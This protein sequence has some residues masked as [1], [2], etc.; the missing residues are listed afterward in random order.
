M[1][2][3]IVCGVAAILLVVTMAVIYLKNRKIRYNAL[4]Y[5]SLSSIYK[6]TNNSHYEESLIESSLM[7][8]PKKFKSPKNPNTPR[9]PSTLFTY[10]TFH[11]FGKS[12]LK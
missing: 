12:E 6:S 7:A 11:T 4:I 5:S 8:T 2:A 3:T 1:T 10:P 9:T